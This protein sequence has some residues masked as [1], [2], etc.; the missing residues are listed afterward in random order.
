MMWT[1]ISNLFL[2][3]QSYY[4]FLHRL[5]L[6][7]DPPIA[8]SQL[9]GIIDMRHCTQLVGTFLRRTEE[10][11][12]WNLEHCLEI[13]LNIDNFLI[14]GCTERAK[15]QGFEH[16]FPMEP[17]TH[18]LDKS[19]WTDSDGEFDSIVQFCWMHPYENQ[20]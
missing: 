7:H 6:S 17:I 3:I 2:E 5:T 12:S 8:T 4:L 10:S 14:L 9:T 15:L 20:F 16:F 18:F 11:V 1:T 19:A 13:W